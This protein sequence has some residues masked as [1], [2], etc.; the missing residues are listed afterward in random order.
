[1][2]AAAGA[3]L[4]ALKLQPD[5]FCCFAPVCV[6]WYICAFMHLTLTLVHVPQTSLLTLYSSIPFFKGHCANL[7]GATGHVL[8]KKPSLACDLCVGKGL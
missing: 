2:E 4:P 1:M 7:P 8:Q 3:A 6:C 5:T